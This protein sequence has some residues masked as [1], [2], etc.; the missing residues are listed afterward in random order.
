MK[1]EELVELVIEGKDPAEVLEY[2]MRTWTVAGPRAGGAAKGL[3]KTIWRQF[4]DIRDT[5]YKNWMKASGSDN[6]KE[7]AHS[8]FMD[9]MQALMYQLSKVVAVPEGKKGPG[10]NKITTRLSRRYSLAPTKLAKLINFMMERY[11][12][13]VHATPHVPAS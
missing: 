5:L 9:F 11:S 13:A 3:H 1:P 8:A 4:P 10:L 6:V 2:D 12:G 7:F